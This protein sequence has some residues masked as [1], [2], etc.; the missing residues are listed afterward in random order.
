MSEGLIAQ[1]DVIEPYSRVALAARALKREQTPADLIGTL[2]F[3]ASPESDFMT[4]QTLV[5]DGGY[6]MH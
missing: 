4:G 2:L 5:V 6:V 3:L 1:R